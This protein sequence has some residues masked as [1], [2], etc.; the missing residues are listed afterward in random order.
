MVL[1]LTSDVNQLHTGK[2]HDVIPTVASGK[3]LH[4]SNMVLILAF[5]CESTGY[6]QEARRY[7]SRKW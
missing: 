5:R 1:T 4:L 6:E 7:Y 2:E 3:Y